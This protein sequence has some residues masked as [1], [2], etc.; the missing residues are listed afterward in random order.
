VYEGWSVPL[1]YD[2]LL[3]KLAVW[4]PTREEA[5]ARAR[6]ALGEY[7]IAGIQTNIQ[8]FEALLQ[9]PQV[10][11]GD[12]HTGLIDEFLST[13]TAPAA[14]SDLTVIAALVGQAF[15]SGPRPV[16]GKNGNAGSNWRHAGRDELLR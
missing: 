7:H 15:G 1:D 6:R 5:I 9:D 11:R 4:A 13:R 12:L 16:S 10:C 3:A 8:F 2:P 14:E